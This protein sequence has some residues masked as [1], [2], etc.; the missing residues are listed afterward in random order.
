[1]RFPLTSDS[2]FKQIDFDNNNIHT[3]SGTELPDYL[4]RN[5]P[6]N[7]LYLQHNELNDEDAVS[8]AHALN[9][10][11]A[12]L[13]KLWLE[14][15]NITEVGR[16]ALSNAVYNPESLN[17]VADCNHTC[18]INIKTVNVFGYTVK[19]NRGRKIYHLLSSWDRE[20]SIV[21]HLNLEFEGEDEDADA[22]SLALV[23]N[24]LE[25]IQQMPRCINDASL[26]I[27]YEIL[28]SWK[29]PALFENSGG[30]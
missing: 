10:N 2:G 24:V 6:L 8:I 30:A 18:E 11:N 4:A 21:Y 1:M 19:E 9:H 28:R 13:R 23:P 27:T 29:M 15:N 14:H 22:N 7:E 5:T 20:G 12:N 17:S 16:N 26:S 25:C 3:G